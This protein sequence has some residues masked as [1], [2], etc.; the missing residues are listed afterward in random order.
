MARAAEADIINYQ[1]V[2][3]VVEELKWMTGGIGPDASIDAVGL[4]AHGRG[5]AAAYDYTKQTLKLS[6]DRPMVLRQIIQATRKGGIVSIPGVYGGILDKIPFGA[7]FSKGLIFKMGQT[8]VHSYLSPL[9]E[10]IERGEVDPSFIITHRMS[11]EDAPAAYRMFRDKQD[12]CIKV[13]LDPWGQAQ[14]A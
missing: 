8:Q 3:D 12:Q 11:L 2:D 4:E 9:L 7:A 1:E 14:A 10:K 6:F 13:V 5:V